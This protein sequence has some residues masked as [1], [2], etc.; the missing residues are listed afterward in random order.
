[1]QTLFGA[2]RGIENDVIDGPNIHFPKISV[3]VSVALGW[4][5]PFLG[6][7]SH[8]PSWLT[9]ALV[10]IVTAP[11]AAGL[12]VLAKRW[13]TVWARKRWPLSDEERI[14]RRRRKPG[15]SDP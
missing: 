5:A 2:Q 8:L 11:I 6:V 3:A 14:E 1:M 10:T 13:A 15:D 4:F 12:A 7:F 9:S